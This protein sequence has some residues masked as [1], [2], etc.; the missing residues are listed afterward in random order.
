[1]RFER[2]CAAMKRASNRPRSGPP[3]RPAEPLTDVLQ[4]VVRDLDME[5]KLR[6]HAAQPAW[7][8]VAGPTLAQHTRA[9]KLVGGVMTVEARSA[10]WLN[11]VAFLRETLRDR[12]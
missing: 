2:C 4:H 11:E 3:K 1:M 6:S 8:R 9:T 5:A 7:S 12:L 10:A